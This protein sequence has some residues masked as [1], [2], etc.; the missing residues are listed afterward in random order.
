ME[1]P[2]LSRM[3]W[4]LLTQGV[5]RWRRKIWHAAVMRSGL[6]TFLILFA[7]LMWLVKQRV[8]RKVEH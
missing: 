6:L 1:D 7:V 8:W 2:R 4:A 3:Y 5:S